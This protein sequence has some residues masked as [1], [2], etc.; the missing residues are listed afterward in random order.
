M[1]HKP[2]RF[3]VIPQWQGSGSSRALQLQ[4]GAEA[5]RGDLP[6]ALTSVVDV[7]LG[8]G[9]ELGSGIR[10]LS[11]LQLV[12]DR[13]RAALADLSGHAGE[14]VIA[15]GGDCGIE[16]AMVEHALEQHPGEVAV[17]WFDAHADL[18]S[19]QTSPSG[20]FHGMVLRTLLG[21]GDPGLVP[22]RPLDGGRLVLAGTRALDDAEADFLAASGVRP[23]P[24]DLL[25]PQSVVDAINATGASSVYLHIDLDVLD[26]AEFS[27]LGYPEPFGVT[28]STLLETIKAICTRFPL[29]GAGITE[30]APSSPEAASDELPTILRIIGA[31]TA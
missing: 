15:I 30:F 17:V 27:S 9:E 10:R 12:R 28:V 13:T 18:N 5:I 3:L 4:D 21:D 20:A 24:A 14:P 29:A 26:P 22:P 6:S 25:T 11:S 7:P 1:S 19:P 2:M 16:L 23:I 31:L 8:A